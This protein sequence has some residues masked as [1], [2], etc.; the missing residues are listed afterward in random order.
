MGRVGRAVQGWI[1]QMCHKT[2]TSQKWAQSQ[3]P[4]LQV[5]SSKHKIS[6]LLSAPRGFINS[7]DVLN[8]SG[9]TLAPCKCQEALHFTHEKRTKTRN[10]TNP[11][12]HNKILPLLAWSGSFQETDP[13]RHSAQHQSQRCGI[14][15]RRHE[16][17]DWND[18]SICYD[19]SSVDDL[20]GNLTNLER[21]KIPKP[22]PKPKT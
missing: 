15:F 2:L 9:Y 13:V 4:W 3:C 12:H 19:Y 8:N 16:G 7:L 21:W 11:L 17:N 22:L 18:P 20:P 6:K 14:I 1:H 10:P 5:G